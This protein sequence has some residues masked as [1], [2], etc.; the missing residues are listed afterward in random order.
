MSSGDRCAMIANFTFAEGTTACSVA[1]SCPTLGGSRDCTHQAPPSM[2]FSRQECWSGLPFLPTGD[3]P[4]PGI[5][6]TTLVSPALQVESLSIEPL[7]LGRLCLA[8]MN[9]LFVLLCHFK[10]ET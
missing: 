5:K 4:H 2:G 9:M 3:L 10:L 1:Q 8:Q 7:M 6:P